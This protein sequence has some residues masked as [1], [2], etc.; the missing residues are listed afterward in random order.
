MPITKRL[1]RV[2]CAALPSGM[3]ACSSPS[4]LGGED[5][6]STGR[7]DAAQESDGGASGDGGIADAGRGWW[8]AYP[9]GCAADQIVSP[10]ERTTAEPADGG[11]IALE[12]V[13]QRAD[14]CAG[15]AVGLDGNDQ[16]SLS[17][18]SL[19]TVSIDGV[20]RDVLAA[21]FH[22]AL[23]ESFSLPTAAGIAFLDP[24]TGAPLKCVKFSASNRQDGAPLIADSTTMKAFL[25][26]T[27]IRA[28]EGE[29]NQT[30]VP[31]I[32]GV[33]ASGVLFERT[34]TG[35]PPVGGGPQLAMDQYGQLLSVWNN[36]LVSID[37]QTGDVLWTK[38]PSELVSGAV[39]V[40]VGFGGGGVGTPAILLQS[41]ELVSVYSV[42]RCGVPT[43]LLFS[44]ERKISNPMRIGDRWVYKRT[45]TDGSNVSVV[46]RSG[47]TI[48]HTEPGC[49]HAVALS[50][51]RLACLRS[52]GT[53]PNIGRGLL[54]RFDLDGGN[55]SEVELS[56]DQNSAFVEWHLS[57][58]IAGADGT[59]IL[60]AGVKSDANDP[61][62]RRIIIAAEGVS[63]SEMTFIDIPRPAGILS[64]LT[65]TTPLL[66]P[67]GML[68][69]PTWGYIYA[70]QTSVF[71]LAASPFPRG[72][73]GGNENRGARGP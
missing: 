45:D 67:N 72:P 64:T 30:N 31:T 57:S 58:L 13:W 39:A 27:P 6:G 12:L 19:S 16:E 36:R 34:A 60:S 14:L 50:P 48:E 35:I 9:N 70:V 43:F 56:V 54:I 21:V 1:L 11:S 44:E 71:G 32:L 49:F 18:V 52:F 24:A 17:D 46:V 51:T 53:I 61:G 66:A 68:F 55:R 65:S 41:E 10:A 8:D 59:V 38:A 23:P 15:L 22:V 63:P 47:A 25:G 62:Y 42:D 4:C 2:L 69:A 3:L 29:L 7:A 37:S 26:A 20:P 33:N 28:F 73:L 5:G 40:G